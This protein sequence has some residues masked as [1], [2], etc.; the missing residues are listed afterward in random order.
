MIPLGI[1]ASSYYNDGGAEPSINLFNLGA[2]ETTAGWTIALSTLAI[3]SDNE[4]DGTNCLKVTL[5]AG[6]TNAS[7]LVDVLG[8]LNTS[9]YYL[10]SGSV[11]N[12][13]LA[14][15]ISL[16]ATCVGDKGN[17]LATPNATTDYIRQG[18]LLQPSDFDGA[19]AVQIMAR[20][21][22]TETQY[23][24]F[25]SFMVNEITA[26]DYASGVVACLVKYPYVDP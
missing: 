4:L 8:I 24:Y 17:I 19:S 25:D 22:G 7:P 16:R 9:K 5:G 21:D 2:C 13:N 15:G 26:D 23:A 11:K 3:D 18:V 12:G 20:V 1:L 10:F 14:T 6:R